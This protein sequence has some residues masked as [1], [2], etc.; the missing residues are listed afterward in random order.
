MHFSSNIFMVTSRDVIFFYN[1]NSYKDY[2]FEG[3]HGDK[4]IGNGE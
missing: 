4:K 3:K 1:A 2:Q